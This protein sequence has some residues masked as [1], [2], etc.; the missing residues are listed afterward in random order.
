MERYVKGCNMYQRMKNRIEKPA[1]KLKLSKVLKKT[2]N[3]LDSGLYYKV[4]IS[5]RERC[6]PSSLQ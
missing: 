6:N 1:G 3:I 2:V 4:T 5:S